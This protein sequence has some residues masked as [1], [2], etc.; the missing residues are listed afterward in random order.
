VAIAC[1]DCGTLLSFPPLPRRSTA[2]CLRCGTQI[3]TTIGRSLTAALACDVATLALLPTVYTL[4]LLKAELLGQRSQSSL[5]ASVSHLWHE[6]WIALAGLSVIFVILL[7]VVRTGLLTLVLGALRLGFHPPWLG[8]VFRW[9][10][11]ID[12]WAMLDVF[13][14]A[15]AVGYCYLTT[16]EHL[17]V[18]IESGARVLVVAGVLTMLSR[19]MLDQRTIW[20]AIGAESAALPCEGAI[21][22]PTC[23]LLQSPAR[24]GGPCPRCGARMYARKPQAIA[25]TAALVS[26]AFILFFPANIYPMNSSDL[27]GQ[28]LQYTNFGYA[29]QLSHLGL[30]PLSGLTFWTSI[31]NPAL[32]MACLGWGLLSVWRRSTRRLV[33]K[34]RLVRTVAE[35]GRWSQTGPFTIVFFVPLIDFG[36]LGAEAVGWGATAFVVMIAL[37]IAASVTFDPRL[38]WDAAPRTGIADHRTAGTHERPD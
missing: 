14:V 6:G 23:G 29:V 38:M 11:W 32:M 3:A 17:D 2:V 18:I 25:A 31:L 20:R 7:P 26:T 19:A 9:T 16:I 35:T 34:T 5:L 30:W 8:R 36:H 12:R 21:G 13:L 15:V 1:P 28:Q 37:I 22:C 27:L 10:V 24:E 4:P 33:L